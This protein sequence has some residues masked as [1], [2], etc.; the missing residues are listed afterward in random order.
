MKISLRLWWVLIFPLLIG[1]YAYGVWGVTARYWYQPK[2]VYIEDTVEGGDP[3]VLVNRTIFRDFDG[4][5]TVSI[6]PVPPDGHVQCAGSDTLRYR[7]GLYG[8][9]TAP[10]TQWADDPWCARLPPGSYYAEAC[11]TVLRPFAGLVPAKTVCIT[12]NIFKIQ[13]RKEDETK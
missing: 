7:G 5:Y 11:W 1:L 10:L 8:P 12:S 6:W 2:S 13:E 9:H 4:R 3:V